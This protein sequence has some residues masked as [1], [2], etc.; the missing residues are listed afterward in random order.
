MPS[1]GKLRCVAIVRTEVSE[2]RRAFIIRVTI[3]DELETIL[4]VSNRRALLSS[5]MSV[6]TR[7]K[8][9]NIPEDGILHIS[10]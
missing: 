9:R 1:S 6:L 3:I 8:L 10:Y 7:A 4:A 5:E 2:E